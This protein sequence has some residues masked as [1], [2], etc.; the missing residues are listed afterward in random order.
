MTRTIC[1]LGATGSIGSQV[2]DILKKRE[3][4]ELVAVTCNE[5]IKALIEILNAFPSVKYAYTSKKYD[6]N[7]LSIKFPNIK[8]FYGKKGIISLIKVSNCNVYENSISGFAGVMPSIKILKMNKILLLANKETL[9]IAGEF[10]NALLDDGYGK[11]I[12]IDSEHVAISKCLYGR[13]IEDINKIVITASGGRF[14]NYTDDELAKV[15]LKDATTNPNWNMGNKITI[16]SNLMSNK[17]FELIEA[18]YLFRVPFDKIS[19]VVNRQSIVHGYVEFNNETRVNVSKPSMSFA[20]EYALN[21]GLPKDL[22][23]GFED[24]KKDVLND[25]KFEELSSS[26]YPV[27]KYAKFVVEHDV[28]A[29]CVLNAC[30]EVA[31][32]AFMAGK[33]KFVDILPIIDTVMAK[34]KFKKNVSLSGLTKAD[35]KARTL[36]RQIISK[37]GVNLWNYYR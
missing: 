19:A 7:E 12:P 16:D 2:I 35:L 23:N 17:C 13:K 29:G 32:A 24:V 4:Y 28:D 26:R 31:V 8:F 36:T 11:L 18:Y 14:F 6:A 9:V 34:Y 5:N 33:I 15:T 22:L 27:L 21:L 30:D 1:V 3:D 10:V 37:M 20:I 25:F